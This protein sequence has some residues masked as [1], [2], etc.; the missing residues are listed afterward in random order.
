MINIIVLVDSRL[1]FKNADF[2]TFTVQQV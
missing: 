1:E 2:Y